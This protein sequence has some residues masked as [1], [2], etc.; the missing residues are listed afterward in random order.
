ML[1]C[2]VVVFLLSVESFVLT[3][4]FLMCELLHSLKSE[5]VSV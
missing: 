4:H 3:G 2:A 5:L 1:S